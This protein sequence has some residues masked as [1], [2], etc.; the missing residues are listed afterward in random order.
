MF[1]D[2][3]VL[4]TLCRV[5]RRALAAF[6]GGIGGPAVCLRARVCVCVCVWQFVEGFPLV[7]VGCLCVLTT[8]ARLMRSLGWM[9][10][11]SR[12][13]SRRSTKRKERR[14]TLAN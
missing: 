7:V 13:A 9:F 3:A 10:Q 11:L 12:S 2:L 4:L 8:G 14:N 1:Q 5:T 6:G